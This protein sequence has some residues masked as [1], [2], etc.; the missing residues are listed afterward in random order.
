[1]LIGMAADMRAQLA[2]MIAAPSCQNG[3]LASDAVMLYS[4]QSLS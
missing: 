2:A 3:H 4:H 1:L